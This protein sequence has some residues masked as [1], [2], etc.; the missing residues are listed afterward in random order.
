MPIDDEEPRMPSQSEPSAIPLEPGDR[1]RIRRRDS[2][3]TGCRGSVAPA[4][5]E[6]AGGAGGQGALPLGYFVAIDGENGMVRPFMLDDIELLRP[7]S[8]R[9][10]EASGL[11]ERRAAEGAPDRRA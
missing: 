10:E 8:V 5:G 7:V 4:P 2:E 1:V 3:Y 11:G 9:R 6:R